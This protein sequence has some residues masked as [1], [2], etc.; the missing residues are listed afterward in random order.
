MYVIKDNFGMYL[1]KIEHIG[2]TFSRSLEKAIASR[3]RNDLV[4]ILDF[5][6]G[7]LCSF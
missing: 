2:V 6:C 7:Y 1:V 5:L 4:H 3:N